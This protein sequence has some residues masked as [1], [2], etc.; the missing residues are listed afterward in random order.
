MTNRSFVTALVLTGALAVQG[1]AA[2]LTAIDR[3]IAVEP[4][5]T[6]QPRYC[7]LVF[8]PEASTRVWLVQDGST[9]YVDRNANGNLTEPGEA[10]AATP[11]PGTD[12]D[13]GIYSFDAGDIADGPR[14]HKKLHVWIHKLD[15]T[16]S[17]LKAHLADYP[18]ARSYRIYLDVE[19]PGWHGS[20]LGG[21]VPQITAN[22]TQGFFRFA[23]ELREAPIVHFGGPWQITLYGRHSLTVDR[24]SDV[25][26]G[27]GTPGLGPGATAYV[28]YEGVIPDNLH[29]TL[30]IKYPSN[31]AGQADVAERYELK[32]R[33]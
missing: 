14:L 19:L 20:G 28:A 31:T 22:D 7:L 9:L 27:L 25:Y 13:E 18:Q 26:L 15:A 10:V 2:D 12:S 29:P 8:G 32:H 30:E 4:R 5:Y 21:R 17:D 3:Q 16:D 6:S 33:C 24:E 1:A 23:E 11:G